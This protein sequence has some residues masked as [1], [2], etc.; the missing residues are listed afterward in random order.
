MVEQ[1]KFHF[2]TEKKNLAPRCKGKER[3]QWLCSQGTLS[4]TAVALKT[5]VRGEQSQ[6]EDLL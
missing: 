4:L 1:I 6:R 3:G 2:D 5:V